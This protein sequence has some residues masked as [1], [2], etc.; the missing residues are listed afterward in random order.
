MRRAV[1]ARAFI[2]EPVLVPADESTSNLDPDSAHVV[3][4]MLRELSS[5][6]TT[7][8]FAPMKWNI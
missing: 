1:I 6:G 7:V 5:N 4:K 2:N 8:I 3:M